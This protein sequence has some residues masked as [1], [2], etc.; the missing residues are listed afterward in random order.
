MYKVLKVSK[1]SYNA[2]LN[3]PEANREQQNEKILSL[4]REEYKS[5]K[6]RYGSPRISKALK[7]RE[8]HVSRPRVAR[9]MKQANIEARMKRRF[10]AAADSRHIFAVSE[11]L[12]NRNFPATT[13]GQAWVSDI[14]YIRT[15]PGW[16]YLTVVL[17]L[18]D[19]K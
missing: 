18:A 16:L 14:T 15:L 7:A 10:K 4:I 3:R 6:K 12:L 5:S 19:E 9:L 13:K 17:D 1:S 8:V 2:S 11:N